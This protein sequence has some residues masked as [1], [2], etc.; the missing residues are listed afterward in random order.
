MS[1]GAGFMR[2]PATA[3]IVVVLLWSVPA[4]AQ[5][6]GTFLKDLVLSLARPDQTAE[7]R[8]R[9]GEKIDQ[10]I[11]VPS[12]ESEEHTGAGLPYKAGSTSA[13]WSRGFPRTLAAPEE[14][15]P[16]IKSLEPLGRDLVRLASLPPVG[17]AAIRA[18]NTLIDAPER[19]ASVGGLVTD[20]TGIYSRLEIQVQRSEYTLRLFAIKRNGDRK[21][22]FTCRTGL[23]SA[24]YPTPRGS[25]YIIRIFDDN[26]LWIPPPD[27]PWAWGQSPSHSV[28]GGHMM[29]F[30]SKRPLQSARQTEP[31]GDLDCVEDKQQMV[32][33]GAYRIHGTNSPWS[34]GSAQS[35]G[36]VRMLN[37]SVKEL[38]DLIKIY[39]GTTTRGRTANGSFVQLAK[40]VRLILF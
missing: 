27:R 36:C 33:A 26:P 37:K 38:S 7:P 6:S 17:Y 31:I 25:Y 15:F 3:V 32:D 12:W 10:L 20:A 30:F 2:W 19:R 23:G 13:G 24:E 11:S 22:L 16:G 14:L 4:C 5:S 28:Y 39:A 29:P 21:V 40:P 34:V 8:I 9:W 1:L 35:H 18:G